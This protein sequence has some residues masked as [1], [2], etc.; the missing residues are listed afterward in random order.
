MIWSEG[1]IRRAPVGTNTPTALCAARHPS[2]RAMLPRPAHP[3]AAAPLRAPLRATSPR[4]RLD[5]IPPR[6]RPTGR[7]GKVNRRSG[8]ESVD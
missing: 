6:I 7:N 8:K 4:V 3:V 5:P 2:V 1:S